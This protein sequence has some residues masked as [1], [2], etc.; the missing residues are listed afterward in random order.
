MPKRRLRAPK[1]TL[2]T[3]SLHYG[4]QSAVG[5]RGALA[6]EAGQSRHVAAHPV[7]VVDTTGAGDSFTAALVSEIL[8]G[9][10][11]VDAVQYAV[12][13]A[14]ICVSGPAVMPLLFFL[15][16]KVL[17]ERAHTR[18]IDDLGG[19]YNRMPV[20]EKYCL[21]S[22]PSPT[23]ACPASSASWGSSPPFWAPSTASATW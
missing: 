15:V 10:P 8:K 23:W 12:R 22:A 19:L 5:A 16:G 17:Y 21:P 3:I 20:G 1:T 6:Y 11:L 4:C 14:A 9:R 7:Q 13:A 2:Y 18:F